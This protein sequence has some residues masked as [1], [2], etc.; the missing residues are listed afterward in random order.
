MHYALCIMHCALCGEI[1]TAPAGLRNDNED[2]ALPGC[3]GWDNFQNRTRK[4]YHIKLKMSNEKLKK[5][6]NDK[7][8]QVVAKGKGL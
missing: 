7:I 4:W 8:S 1:A 6:K 2:C 5:I 3:L